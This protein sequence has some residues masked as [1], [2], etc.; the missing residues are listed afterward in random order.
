MVVVFDASLSDAIS[1]S[2]ILF[3]VSGL[4]INKINQI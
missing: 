3:P 2:P 1:A 4:N